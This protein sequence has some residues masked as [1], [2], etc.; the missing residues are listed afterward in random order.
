M[1][2]IHQMGQ[3]RTEVF[4]RTLIT[5]TAGSPPCHPDP[6]SYHSAYV[7]WITSKLSGYLK[8]MVRYTGDSPFIN[9]LTACVANEIFD[10]VQ[11]SVKL[12]T[13]DNEWLSHTMYLWLFLT[14]RRYLG[15]GSESLLE[16]DSVWIISG[17]VCR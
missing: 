14:R 10:S 7:S 8:D 15:V 13:S 11:S 9:T 12:W 17:L 4:W 6:Y 16:H 1:P 3:S 2:S 5:N